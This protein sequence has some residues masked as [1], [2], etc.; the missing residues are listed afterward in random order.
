MNIKENCATA[1][2]AWCHQLSC[3]VVLEKCLSWGTQ[4]VYSSSPTERQK[5][6]TDF[7]RVQA[8]PWTRFALTVIT[9]SVLLRLLLLSALVIWFSFIL[10]FM[11][12]P[13]EVDW[14]L[15]SDSY[16]L[17]LVCEVEV[18]LKFESGSLQVHVIWANDSMQGRQPV[19]FLSVNLRPFFTQASAGEV[20]TWGNGA[21][22][23][24]GS[25][26]EGL[27][28]MPARLEAM[29]SLRTIQVQAAKFH[30]MALTKDG[31]LFTWGFGRGG[32][33]GE[34]LYTSHKDV[35]DHLILYTSP[36]L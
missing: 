28:E 16:D 13:S 25:G 18:K 17:T 29:H 1:A 14:N 22:Y 30:S 26:A 6:A 5:I 32:R 35:W 10:N 23:Q 7:C 24:L 11:L 12:K 4:K 8:H 36:F 31:R 33:L 19:H 34:I 20:C 9:P 27:Q 3:V 21:N 2:H 15:P